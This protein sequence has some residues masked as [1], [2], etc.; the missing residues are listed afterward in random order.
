MTYVVEDAQGGRAPALSILEVP[1]Y[2]YTYPLKQV[3][4]I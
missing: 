4:Q 1:F 2:L 3:Y